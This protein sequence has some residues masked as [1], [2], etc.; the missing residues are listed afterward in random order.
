MPLGY[1]QLLSFR[2][3]RET[4]D[5]EPILERRRN[6]VQHI[7]RRDKEDLRKIVFDVKIVILEHVVLFRI[8]HFQERRAWVAAKIG[9]ELIDFVEQQNWI[10]R[11]RFLH[12]LN[13]LT[14]QRAN[15]GA[16]MP[17]N[18]GFV[19]D[20]SQAEPHELSARSPGDRF[21]QAGLADSRR[22][23]ETED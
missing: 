11:A 6:R 19:T 3:A 12:H 15:I 18:F 4:Q 2:V 20:A 22:T 23:N 13:D 9:A 1:F 21:T 17:S 8:E 14:G 7:C 16:A 10:H 5:F